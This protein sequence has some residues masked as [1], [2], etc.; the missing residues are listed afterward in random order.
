VRESSAFGTI[1]SKI[2]GEAEEPPQRH[3]LQLFPERRCRIVECQNQHVG[4]QDP[5][6]S[7]DIEIDKRRCPAGGIV[8][9]QLETDQVPAQDEEKINAHPAVG[10]NRLQDAGDGIAPG[11]VKYDH[12]DGD[13]SQRIQSM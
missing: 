11:V 1:K 3:H 6:A 12:N 9:Q 10:M 8:S 5:E 4:R 2:H 13:R 7:S